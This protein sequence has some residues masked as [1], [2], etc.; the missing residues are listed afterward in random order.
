MACKGFDEQVARH[1]RR[2]KDLMDQF[3]CVRIIQANGLDLSL[4]QFDFDLTFAAFFLN[5]DKTIYGRYGTRSSHDEA[6]SE[7][8]MEGF[9]KSLAAALEIHRGYPANKGQLV[10]KKAA[11]SRYKVPE[12]YPSLRGRFKPTLA[13]GKNVARSCMHCHMVQA[14]ERKVFRSARKPIPD[15]VLYAWPMPDVVGLKLDPK[16]TAN[17]SGIT[18]DSAAQRA[19]FR[20]GDEILTLDGQRI[21]SVADVQW[22][23]HNSRERAKVKVEVLRGTRKLALTLQLDPGWRRKSDISWRTTT[24]DLRRMGTGGLVLQDIT[25]AE[26]RKFRLADSKL[27][28]RVKHV[29]QYGAHAAAKRAGFK[30]GDIIV[31]FDSRTSRLTETDLLAYVLQNKVAGMK[32]PV[33]VLRQGKR[34]NLRLP[35]Q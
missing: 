31:T 5:A 16:Q 1:D 23:L 8:S 33:T 18:P 30:K 17:V 22:V 34:V 12:A 9:R 29:G 7:I 21:I 19:G 27:A 3:V 15:R 6:T 4:F 24:W 25:A 2:V 35:M 20:P 14:A 26:R 11:E 13:T 28:L 32:V 10:G